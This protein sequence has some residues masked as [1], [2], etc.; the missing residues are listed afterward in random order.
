[1]G[2]NYDHGFLDYPVYAFTENYSHGHVE[3]WH[4]HDR[5]QLIHTLTGVIRVQTTEGTWVTPPGRG[6]WIPAYQLHALHISGDVQAYGVFIEP[7]ARDQL[8]NHCRVVTIS[9]LLKELIRHA[10]QIQS[11]IQPHS[12]EQRLLELILD[13]VALLHVLPFNLP[14]PQNIKLQKL[15]VAIKNDLAQDWS[16]AHA[17]ALLHIS[18]KTLTR[19]FQ[20]ETQMH[21]SHWVRQ[22]R[23]MQA[24][25]DL[26]MNK[27]I[28]NVALDLGYDSASAFS[29]MFKRETSLTP[30][31]YIQQFQSDS[32]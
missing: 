1:M 27:S 3:D 4:S 28:F 13:E 25:I 9:P 21:F 10:M 23:L 5:V 17:A 6:V 30:S 32:L 8:V 14:E 12:R 26:A 19:H 20:K 31:E 29:A 18:P 24:M 22:A 16:L 2:N 11:P 7:D 15:C